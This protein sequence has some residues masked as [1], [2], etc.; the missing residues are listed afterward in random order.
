VGVLAER[1]PA[2]LPVDVALL[3]PVG[4]AEGYARHLYGRLRDAD[5]A[6]LDVVVAVA[7]AGDG[8]AVAVRDR[9]RRAATATS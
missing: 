4:D 2:D 9:L 6:G 7:P 8:I 1:P 3:D 5:A